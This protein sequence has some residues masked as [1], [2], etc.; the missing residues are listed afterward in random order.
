MVDKSNR[1]QITAIS[2][3]AA[4]KI[5][6]KDHGGN[7]VYFLSGTD[8]AP[9][10]RYYGFIV[11]GENTVISTINYIDESKQSGDIT[12]IGMNIGMYYPIPG[13]FSTI[14]LTSGNVILLKK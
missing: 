9:E 11:T 3:I 14:T 1:M 7:G 8:A 4:D 13:L 12:Q 5:N 6:S 10:D 2:E